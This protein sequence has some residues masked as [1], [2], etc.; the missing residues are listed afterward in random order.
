MGSRKCRCVALILLVASASSALA[1]KH[2]GEVVHSP[3]NDA[4]P[5]DAIL[6]LHIAIQTLT[7]GFVFPIGMVLGLVRSRW[8]IPTQVVG[9]VLTSG[10]YFL[11]HSHGGRQFKETVHGSFASFLYVPMVMQLCIGVY[12]KLHVHEKS[13]RPYFVIVHGLLGKIWP[14]L[15]WTQMVF[16]AA[17]LGGYCFDGG[18]NQCLAHYIMGSGFIAYGILLAIALLAGSE[19]I[20]STGRSQEW[21]DSVVILLWGIV[22]TFTEHHG[23]LTKWSHKDLQHT[24][25]GILWWAGGALGVYLSRN[26]R[27]SVIPGIIIIITGWAMSA[28]EQAM[29]ISTKIHSIFGIVLMSAGATRIIEVSLVLRDLARLEPASRE[30]EPPSPFIRSFQHLPP[31]VGYLVLFM[32]ATDEELKFVNSIEVDHVT[33]ALL[34]FCLAFVIYLHTVFLIN[35]W[36]T[37]GRNAAVRE[38]VAKTR[39]N[40]GYTRVPFEPMDGVLH[41]AEVFELGP[42]D[43]EPDDTLEQSRRGKRSSNVT[44]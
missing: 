3:D 8:H 28:H 17:T 25:L 1:H 33:Y 5:I 36:R 37:L 30:L 40:A 7:W 39:G 16:G 31:L 6:Y 2:D 18:L 24:S 26:G 11:G 44:D 38:G 19:W 12:L 32:S 15:G 21:F 22:N 42:T 23:P 35:L 34:M 9:F 20:Q 10:G 27:R 29:A 13:I 4:K 41:D 14:I 43:Y